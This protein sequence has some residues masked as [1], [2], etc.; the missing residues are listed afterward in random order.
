[1]KIRIALVFA[2]ALLPVACDREGSGSPQQSLEPE[3]SAANE[4]PAE[5]GSAVGQKMSLPAPSGPYK[6][7]V[8]EFS[9]TDR[10]RS[11]TFK[12]GTRR[13][14]HA[15]VYYPADRVSGAPRLR[16]TDR[17]NDLIAERFILPT[18]EEQKLAMRG[19]VSHS[20]PQA[21]VSSAEQSFP[22]LVFSHGG[23]GALGSNMVQMEHLASHGYIVVSVTHPYISSV[24][25]FDDGEV[26]T[27]DRR[28]A[29][30]FLNT[31]SDLA[32]LKQ[33]VSPDPA[34]RLQTARANISNKDGMMS[35]AP[36]FLIWRDD[37]IAA[38]DLIE[39][40]NV[41]E[42][43]K[44][45]A[46]KADVSRLGYFGMS[47]GAAGAAAAHKDTR[48][49][50]AVNLDG[51]NWDPA[52]LDADVRVP[53]LVF[54]N[55]P[56]RALLAFPE[57]LLA[58]HP[59]ASFYLHSEFTYEPLETMG[60]REDVVRLIVEDADHIDFTDRSLLPRSLRP[61]GI[62]GNRL[63]NI[64]ND[65]CL[66]FFDRYVKGDQGAWPADLPGKYEAVQEA[67]LTYVRG[68]AMENR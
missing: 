64:M 38:V 13:R 50:A 34:V 7:G 60:T 65:Y 68:W 32:Y 4:K 1:M 28:L 24:V 12:P 16:H 26:I 47:F 39:A 62:D 10:S 25:L 31:A 54:H 20:Y 11:E 40:G 59:E 61:A 46:K 19:V 58:D 5:Q 18:S 35:L 6:V 30:T 2:A 17:E 22:L 3:T 57:E 44:A 37:M 63:Q 15:R 43:L 29:E 27:P 52:L 56:E 41:P 14:L 48:A 45:V 42:P 49:S 51:G 33:F 8:G 55:D 21:E 23:W 67:D 9:F 36:H 53:T 66:A